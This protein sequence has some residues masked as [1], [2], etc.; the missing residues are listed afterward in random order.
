MAYSVHMSIT[1]VAD[2]KA[3]RDAWLKARKNYLTSSDFFSWIGDTPKWW[4]DTR[5]DI[6]E[7]K[8]AGVPKEFP[9]DVQVSIE[10]GSFDEEHIMRKFGVEI[11]ARVEPS[12]ALT[13]NSRWPHLAASIDGFVHRPHALGHFCFSQDSVAM[14]EVCDTLFDACKDGPAVCEIKKSTSAGWSNGKVSPWYVP[15]VQ[16]QLYILE[17][18]HAVIV[19]DTVLRGGGGRLFW[20]LTANV[21]ER[22]PNFEKTMDRLDNEFE[23]A[24]DRNKGEGNA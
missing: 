14:E 23:Q 2:A 22:D 20:N 5:Y 4:S 13:V 6:L 7:Q 16:G 12:N 18:D 1:K 11:G 15:Q 17:M 24:L 19:A 9:A 8:F 10:H 21:I 3:D